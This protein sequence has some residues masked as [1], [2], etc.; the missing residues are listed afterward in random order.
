M[1]FNNNIIN[2]YNLS[3]NKILNFNHKFLLIDKIR[4]FLIKYNIIPIADIINRDTYAKLISIVVNDV[5][6][7]NII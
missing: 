3:N 6:F 4:Y 7:Y 1:I 2:Y 5:M